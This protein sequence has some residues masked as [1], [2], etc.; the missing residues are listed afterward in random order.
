MR[1]FLLLWCVILAGCSKNSNQGSSTQPSGP[2]K[3]DPGIDA[4]VY[5]LQT[6]D[7][8]EGYVEKPSAMHEDL[9][10]F[11]S[12]AV[13]KIPASDPDLRQELRDLQMRVLDLSIERMTQ[14]DGKEAYASHVELFHGV[15]NEALDKIKKIAAQR[16]A[17]V[18][19]R[20]ENELEVAHPP[21]PK[22]FYHSVDKDDLVYYDLLAKNSIIYRDSS[23]S[24]QDKEMRP[25]LT[26]M[27]PAR[28]QVSIWVNVRVETKKVRFKFNAGAL[29]QET[30]GATNSTVFPPSS[31][32]FFRQLM[33][34]KTLSIE[35]TPHRSKPQTIAF[36]LADFKDKPGDDRGCHLY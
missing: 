18:E 34:A 24:E 13:D 33:K 19:L 15:R 22:W 16:N 3:K 8:V 25:K 32:Q 11:M 17:L 27:C 26:I 31:A 6:I 4:A 10:G 20:P 21:A 2:L 30:W 5:A 9:D 36:D 14:P 12:A 7:Y 29:M 1:C 28:E 23:E 35:L